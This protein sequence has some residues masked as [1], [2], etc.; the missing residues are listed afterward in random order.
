MLHHPAISMPPRRTIL[1]SGYLSLLANHTRNIRLLFGAR[2]AVLV[3]VSLPLGITL[4][5]TEILFGSALYALLSHYGL[6]PTGGPSFVMAIVSLHPIAAVVGLGFLIFISRTLMASMP[7]ITQETFFD[8]LRQAIID[9]SLDHPGDSSGMTTTEVAYLA[10]TVAPRAAGMITFL[11]R[12]S[13]S[14]LLLVVLMAGIASLSL[15]MT[16]TAVVASVVLLFPVFLLRHLVRRSSHDYHA[17]SQAFTPRLLRD[18]RSLMFLKVSGKTEGESLILRG[19]SRQARRNYRT[20]MLSLGIQGGLPMFVGTLVVVLLLIV[21]D[22][23]SV[24]TLGEMIPFIYLLTRISAGASDIVNAFGTL[25]STWPFMRELSTHAFRLFPKPAAQMEC[26][27]SKPIGDVAKLAVSD[28]AIGRNAVLAKGITFDVGKGDMLLISGESGRGKTTLLMTLVGLIKRQ[29]GRI[30]W[31]D[32]DVEEVDQQSLRRRI[33]YAGSDPYLLDDTIENNLL[34]GRNDISADTG[35]LIRVLDLA[36]AQF[37]MELLGGLR[38]PLRESGDGISAGQK[39]RLSIARAILG[40]PDVLILDEATA[41]VDEKIEAELIE[42]I[43]KA[44]PRMI[45]IAVSHRASLQRFATKFL[46]I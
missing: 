41:N 3:A 15:T 19:F 26:T 31:N 43:R 24:F 23:L 38:F 4:G 34:L 9:R 20:M 17:N 35:E 2:V 28:L 42:G 18:I 16:A 13:T 39:Q 14:A 32:I 30:A 1:Q 44:Y 10:G 27:P 37:V 25:A 45:I 12:V 6:A 36:R 40:R 11:M 5:V 46:S 21:N 8:R 7:G 29:G 33:G 22:R